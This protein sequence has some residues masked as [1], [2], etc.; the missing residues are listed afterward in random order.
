MLKAV[1]EE[2]GNGQLVSGL[3]ARL[4]VEPREVRVPGVQ[5]DL[6]YAFIEQ[7][8]VRG[9]AELPTIEASVCLATLALLLAELL[10]AL[11]RFF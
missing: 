2:V 9:A 6:D 5:D 1:L 10:D 4:F 7:L 3:V 11:D 8:V